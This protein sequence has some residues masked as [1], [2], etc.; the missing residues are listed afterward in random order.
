MKRGELKHRALRVIRGVLGPKRTTALLLRRN[1]RRYDAVGIIFIHIPKCAGTSISRALYGGSLGHRTAQELRECD[2]ET[3][4]RQAA[5]SVLR[6]PVERAYSAWRY[7]RDGGAEDGWAQPH[8]DY[9]LPEF[10]SFERFATEWLPPR[11]TETLDYVFRSQA[12][13]VED[14]DGKLLVDDLIALPA[15]KSEWPRIAALGKG[16]IGELP[17]LNSKGGHRAESGRKPVSAPVIDALRGCYPRDFELY[18]SATSSQRER[19]HSNE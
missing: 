11:D 5:F 7:C 9:A 10:Q 2:A 16:D 17:I 8:P 15:L 12:G 4:D 14:A 18:T 1:M 19:D 13:F 3:F 6:D